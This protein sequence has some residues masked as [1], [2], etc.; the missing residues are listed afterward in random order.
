MTLYTN[1]D[2]AQLLGLSHQHR[3]SLHEAVTR[4][5]EGAGLQEGE[6]FVIAGGK[7]LYT[8]EGVRKMRAHHQKRVAAGG[9]KIDPPEVVQRV[10][11]LAKKGLTANAIATEMGTF[12]AIVV[13]IAKANGITIDPTA[14]AVTHRTGFTAKDRARLARERETAT[15]A[16]LA[17]RYG[18]TV[19]T[20]N[21]HLRLQREEAGLPKRKKGRPE[22]T[23]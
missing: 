13:R 11:R 18:M 1:A 7:H 17:A 15:V 12:R 23:A 14:R 19:H 4:L 6:D 2:I 3:S 5:R 20:I 21:R 10:R 8:W 9:K 16:E 22:K